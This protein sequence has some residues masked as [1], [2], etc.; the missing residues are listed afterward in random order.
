MASLTTNVTIASSLVVANESGVV[1]PSEIHQTFTAKERIVE[2]VYNIDAASS[3]IID[4]LA[5]SFDVISYMKLECL[6]ANKALEIRVNGATTGFRLNPIDTVSKAFLEG[7]IDF[8]T[9]EVINLDTNTNVY[10][11]LS[12]F[13]KA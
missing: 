12:V 9:L 13:E 3:I 8:D 10:I 4:K 6:T 1:L 11:A 2:R 5:E 7:Q